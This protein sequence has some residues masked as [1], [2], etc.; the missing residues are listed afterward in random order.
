MD[1]DSTTDQ[2]LCV[3]VHQPT[4]QQMEIVLLLRLSL[5]DDDGV[6]GVVSTGASSRHVGVMSKNVN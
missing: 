3:R 1:D 4:R 2:S 6:P 5:A